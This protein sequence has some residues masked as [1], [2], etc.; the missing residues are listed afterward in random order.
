MRKG[1]MK[2][3]IQIIKK[4]RDEM[5]MYKQEMGKKDISKSFTSL[6]F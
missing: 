1:G 6:Y 2:T 3:K 4:N 5:K